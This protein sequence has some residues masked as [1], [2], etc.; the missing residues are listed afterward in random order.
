MCPA[1]GCLVEAPIAVRALSAANLGKSSQSS[2]QW[3]AAGESEHTDKHL[4]QA[5][6]QRCALGGVMNGFELAG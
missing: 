3:P 4:E 6:L 5:P 1:F 2:G